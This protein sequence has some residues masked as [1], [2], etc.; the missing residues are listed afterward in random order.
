MYNNCTTSQ[1]QEV[2]KKEEARAEIEGG[3]EWMEG[4]MNEWMTAAETFLSHL[5]NVYHFD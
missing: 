4:W 2:G 5:S 3:K 1:K